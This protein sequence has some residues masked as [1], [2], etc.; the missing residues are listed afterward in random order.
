MEILQGKTVCPGLFA[1]PL[2]I[3]A[4]PNTKISKTLITPAEVPQELDKVR[5]ALDSVCAALKQIYEKTRGSLGETKAAIFAT[6]K[7]MLEDPDYRDSIRTMIAEELVKADFAVQQTGEKFA[8]VFTSMDDAYMQ[9]RAADV[10]D[11]SQQVIV[12]LAPAATTTLATAA[13]PYVLFASDLK[14]SE[15]MQLDKT[16]LGALITAYGSQNSHTAI[17]AKG[18]GIPTVVALGDLPNQ[19]AGNI[20]VIVDAYKGNVYLN[21]DATQQKVFARKIATEEKNKALLLTLKGKESITKT[22]QKVKV[23]ANIGSPA[24]LSLV[25]QNDAE[26]IGLFRSEFMYLNRSNFP[27][28]E[29]LFA[30]Y[31]EVAAALQGKEV[32]IRT[33]DI[34][35]DKKATYFHLPQEANPALGY[36]AIRICLSEP[37]IFKTQLRAILRASAFGKIAIMFPMITS[38]TE[39]EEI[40]IIVETVKA[41]LR[42]QKIAFDEKIPLGI[43]VETPAAALC[44]NELGKLV[45]FFSIGTNDLTQYTLA[46]DRQSTSLGKFFNA[47][48][49]AVLKLIAMTVDNAHKNGIWCGICG[50]LGADLHLTE[51]FLRLGIDELSVPPS[52]VLPLREK[53]RSLS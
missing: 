21:P 31:K 13:T 48:H 34:G 52:R 11:I 18:L 35:A 28:E 3:Y 4:S 44:S 37:K 10:L 7:Q 39:V 30:A 15:I 20:S 50:E 29:E 49:P 38:V 51:E 22:G 17:L 25:K 46:M 8:A 2:V 6:H 42:Q 14:P 9:A 45:D 5:Q 41:D 32:V 47:H 24:D 33:L 40:K 26:G 36:R 27:A 19:F 1:G 43:M 53:I 12:A 16:R 23:F